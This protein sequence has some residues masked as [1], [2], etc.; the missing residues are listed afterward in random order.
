MIGSELGQLADNISKDCTQEA[1]F[2]ANCGVTLRHDCPNFEINYVLDRANGN[3]DVYIGFAELT[4][5]DCKS[6]YNVLLTKVNQ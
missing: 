6:L 1:V 5:I 4:R 2:D 3:P